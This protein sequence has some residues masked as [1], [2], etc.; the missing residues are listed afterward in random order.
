MKFLYIK[1]Q[2]CKHKGVALFCAKDSYCTC[3]FIPMI[4]LVVLYDERGDVVVCVVLAARV[5]DGE[6]SV[7]LHTV[8]LRRPVLTA[9]QTTTLNNPDTNKIMKQSASLNHSQAEQ[10]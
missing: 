2:Y 1:I 6:V 3:I 7:P 8:L 4:H 10:I 5:D 9:L